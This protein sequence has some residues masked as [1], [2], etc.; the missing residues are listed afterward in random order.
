MKRAASAGMLRN[1]AASKAVR[2]TAPADVVWRPS[3]VAR[4]LADDIGGA[5]AQASPMMSPSEPLRDAAPKAVASAKAHEPGDRRPVCI[6]AKAAA[7]ED[8]PQG[9]R[10]PGLY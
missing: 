6:R 4:R 1:Q 3:T 7:A 5:A 9:K 10:L 2:E 8:W